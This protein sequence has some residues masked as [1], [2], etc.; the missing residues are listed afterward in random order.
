MPNFLLNIGDRFILDF[1]KSLSALISGSY[2]WKEVHEVVKL[3]SDEAK[4]LLIKKEFSGW[5]VRN[6]HRDG[7][8]ELDQI[9]IDFIAPLFA[10]DNQGIFIILRDQLGETLEHSDTQLFS[11]FQQLVYSQVH[12]EFIRLF[13]ERDPVGKVLYRSLRYILSKHPEW[14]KVKAG[15]GLQ[16]IT[17][18]GKVLPVSTEIEVSLQPADSNQSDKSLTGMMENY[19]K[20]AINADGQAVVLNKLFRAIRILIQQDVEWIT[21]AHEEI[22]PLLQATISRRISETLIHIE[23]TLI[24]NYLAKKKICSD[25][26]QI[27]RA[28]L[29]DI[30]TDYANGG[31]DETYITYLN[32]HAGFEISNITYTG[33]YKKQ[34]E[35]VAKTAK[36]DFSA[37]IR[38]DFN[39]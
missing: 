30:L 34:F 14:E 21:R 23:N 36:R 33:Q 11:A 4:R 17:A 26:K 12:H 38:S 16:I 25:E 35:Y 6:F 20:T 37:R 10:R 19:L 27:F 2:T 29:S 18:T 9:A 22:D 28:A 15:N 1:R 8:S 3:F 32:R 24:D 5:N 13:Q 39:L 7:S 31:V